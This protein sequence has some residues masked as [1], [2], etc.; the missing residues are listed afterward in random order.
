MK[1]HLAIRITRGRILLNRGG[2]NVCKVRTRGRRIIIVTIRTWI[3]RLS[4]NTFPQR[5][6]R[7]SIINCRIEN[8][9]PMTSRN[10][11]MVRYLS[12]RYIFSR[13]RPLKQITNELQIEGNVK[14][15]LCKLC[16]LRFYVSVDSCKIWS[17]IFVAGSS[18]VILHSVR[19]SIKT[20]A[21]K[22]TIQL[23]SFFWFM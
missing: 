5:R 3:I 11:A 15:K 23:V 16:S 2:W 18:N 13:A 10:K 20:V 6:K 1:R 8:F 22:V 14:M 19:R 7:S 21:Q 17:Y 9:F 12:Q 4:T